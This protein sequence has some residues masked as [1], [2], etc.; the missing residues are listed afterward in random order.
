MYENKLK[1]TVKKTFI[2]KQ[3]TEN[4]NSKKNTQHKKFIKSKYNTYLV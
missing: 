3:V 4:L 1:S 2:N